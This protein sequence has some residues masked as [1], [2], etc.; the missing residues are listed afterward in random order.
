M[1][2]LLLALAAVIPPLAAS[3][4]EVFLKG[5]GRVSGR[6][7]SRTATTVEVDVGAGR[8]GVPASSVLRIEEGRSAL[9][10]YEER[11]GR[12]APGDLEGWL[13][14]GEWASANSLAT[15]ATSA[16]HHALG[17]SPNDPRANA[18]LGNV[19]VGGRWVSEE[20]S[21]RARG[22]VQYEGEWM[23]PAEHEA[24]LRERAA[25]AEQERQRL[26][27]ESRVREAEAKA[28]EAEARA[29]KAEAEAAEA[30]E[31]ND[32]LPLWYG[33]GAGPVAWPTTNITQ[34]NWSVTRPV[35][36]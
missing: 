35:P 22:F 21:Y 11:A 4:D 27:G 24:I 23:T 6:I 18:A 15:Q 1:R 3:A 31:A 19:Q 9:Q 29:R 34:P 33:W 5:G 2:T 30:E 12:L 10:E 26:E 32:G 8:I 28:T 36:R 20:E 7:V 13:A 25:E 16:Y 17:A 14:L